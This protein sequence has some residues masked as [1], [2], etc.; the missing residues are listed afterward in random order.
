MER[1]STWSDITGKWA[2]LYSVTVTGFNGCVNSDA[3]AV[4]E[5]GIPANREIQNV[6]HHGHA[7]FQFHPNNSCGR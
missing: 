4:T 3:V 7:V 5:A 1:W 6:N 2:G